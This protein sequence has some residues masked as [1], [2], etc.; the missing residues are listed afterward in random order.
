VWQVVGLARR[1]WHGG[2]DHHGLAVSPQ[3]YTG[4]VVTEACS[5]LRL[6][7]SCI[8]QLKAQGLSGTCN[9]SKEEEEE[10][11]WHRGRDHHG[12]A[13]S[14]QP[15]LSLFVLIVIFCFDVTGA[16]SLSLSLS[17]ILRSSS[18]SPSQVHESFFSK[19]LY[20]ATLRVK[21][22]H[23]GRDHHGLAVSPAPSTPPSLTLTLTLTL[24]HTHTN[25]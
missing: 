8:T 17:L 21:A 25:P 2:R 12:L 20:N 4:V 14:P 15:S 24:T 23:G 5:Y 7:D 16:S 11:G 13:V 9:E 22:W 1:G 18:V 10:E 6:I 3:P 19:L